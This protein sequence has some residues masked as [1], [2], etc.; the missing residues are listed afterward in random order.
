MAESLHHVG[1]S[2]ADLDEAIA[3]YHE[4]LGLEVEFRFEIPALRGAMVRSPGGLRMELL[5]R[6]GS[7][8]GINGSHPDAA[9]LTR[10][11]G[12]IALTV[13][14]LAETYA[15]LLDAGAAAVWE[16]RPSPEPGVRMAFVHDPEGNLIELLERS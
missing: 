7:Q 14:G 3:W 11:Y 5:E 2:V 16:P 12:H 13:E 6:P 1:L 8:A 9:L 10:G 4:A 15:R